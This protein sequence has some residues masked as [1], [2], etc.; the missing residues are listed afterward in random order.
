MQKIFE[1]KLNDYKEYNN[2]LEQNM[3]SI[4]EFK[5]E[6]KELKFKSDLINDKSDLKSFTKCLSFI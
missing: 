3:R 6:P 5:S 2:I 4:E 1:I